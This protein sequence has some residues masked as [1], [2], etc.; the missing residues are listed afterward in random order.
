MEKIYKNGKRLKKLVVN[1]WEICETRWWSKHKA[2]ASIINPEKDDLE[3]RKFCNFLL[4]LTEI[5]EGSF[6][7]KTKFMA[8]TLLEKWTQFK[9]LLAVM[10]ILNL[11][12]ITSPLFKILQFH[13]L[14][15]LKAWQC[16]D[17]CSEMRLLWFITDKRNNENYNKLYPKCKLFTKKINNIFIDNQLVEL[18]EDFV[19]KRVSIKKKIWRIISGWNKNINPFSKK[20]SNLLP[21]FRY[22]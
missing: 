22:C 19:S 11:F 4:F 3:S 16:V 18:Q 17:Y 9:T 14:D 15:Y 8:H 10:I 7:C 6:D 2:L 12:S 21:N 13:A 5:I 1:G 20:Q